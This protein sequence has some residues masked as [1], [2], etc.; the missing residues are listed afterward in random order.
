MDNAQ[1]NPLTHLDR[2]KA[3]FLYSSALD[4]GDFETV[5]LMLEEA[6]NDAQLEQMILELN[7]ELGREYD[8]ELATE[9]V[10]AEDAARVKQILRECVPSGVS[11]AVGDDEVELP[12]L[13][14][15]SVLARMQEDSS[16]GVNIR[17]EAARLQGALQQPD[18]LLPEDLSQR[19][20]SNLFGEMG[21]TAGGLVQKMFRRIALLLTMSREQDTAQLAAAR[22][23]R[24][25]T[26]T[27]RRQ[28]IEEQS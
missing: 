18:A 19:G 8:K 21:L 2:E 7:D 14:V 23:Q 11:G 10:L 13:T 15:R 9:A 3:L 5:S 16:L 12:P 1:T 6:R 20:I 26:A 22:R 4:R 24:Q 17:Q 27:R 25:Q 28:Q